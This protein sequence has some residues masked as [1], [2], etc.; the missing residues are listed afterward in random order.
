MKRIISFITIICLMFLIG[1]SSSM[2]FRYKDSDKYSIGEAS[3]DVK[4]V[5]KIKIEWAGTNALISS[6]EGETIHIYED[7]DE[8]TSDKYKLHYYLN[9]DTLYIEPCASMMFPQFNFHT[10]VLH[11]EIPNTLTMD[12][13]ELFD[14]ELVSTS[15]TVSGVNAQKVDIDSVSG[16]LTISAITSDEVDIDA[17]SGSITIDTITAKKIDIDTT[18]GAV[19]INNI[20]GSVDLD[21]VSGTIDIYIAD[22]TGFEF[23]KIECISGSIENEFG[24]LKQGDAIVKYN[25]DTVSGNITIHKN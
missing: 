3:F 5:K 1:C 24:T 16:N 15:G 6:Y 7:L 25:I 9:N 17:V 8:G 4:D 23:E 12:N 13:L 18:S 2:H 14:L 19:A 20:V 11:V 10:K 21:T 22:G